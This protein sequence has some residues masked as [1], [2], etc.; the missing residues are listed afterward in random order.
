MSLTIDA[1]TYDVG[2]KVLGRKT[3]FIFKFAERN[4]DGV[5]RSEL[6]GV[7][8]N[9]DIAVGMSAF[10]IAAYAALYLKITEPV[11][12]H[13]ITMLGATWDCY[14]ALIHDEVAKITP[15]QTYYRNL[16]FSAIAIAPARVPE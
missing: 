6:I 3:E 7:Y 15:T 9:Y 4:A 14:F 11:T 12:S 16:L 5:L 2:V 1:I 10:N 8:F 13:S